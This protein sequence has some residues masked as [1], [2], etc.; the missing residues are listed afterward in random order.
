MLLIGSFAVAYTA[1]RFL[2]SQP[3]GSVPTPPIAESSSEPKATTVPVVSE[4]AHLPPPGMV[5]IPAAEFTMGTDLPDSWPDERPAHRVKVNAFWLDEHEVTNA[6]FAE[7]VDA[8]GYVTL[9]EKAPDL[10]EIMRAGP[11]GT[12]PPPREMLVPGSL[13]FSH[14][15]SPVPLDNYTQWWNWTPGAD[16]RHPEG[17]DS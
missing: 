10:A 6:Q 3:A 16:W 9:A 13:V 7:F 4:A 12:P 8:T 5:L 11:P 1:R 2:S 14:T 17:P 15:D